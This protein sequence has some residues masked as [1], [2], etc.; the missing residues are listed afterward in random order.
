M[1]ASSVSLLVPLTDW[2]LRKY[3]G[4]QELIWGGDKDCQHQWVDNIRKGEVRENEALDLSFANI[5][6]PRKS[7]PG[8]FVKVE[9]NQPFCS[10]C[11]AWKG[12]LGLEPEPDCGR[13]YLKLKDSLTDK[14]REYVMGELKRLGLSNER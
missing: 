11:G 5:T 7:S 4:E 13:P 10:L 14:Q 1:K 6:E 3:S 8:A 9:Y 12:S 2:G